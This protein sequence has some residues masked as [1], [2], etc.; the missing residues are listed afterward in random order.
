MREGPLN[1]PSAPTWL[2][3]RHAC[4]AV[5]ELRLPLAAIFVSALKLMAASLFR[6]HIGIGVVAG[7]EQLLTT[8]S[9]PVPP[10][11]EK[12]HVGLD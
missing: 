7:D 5:V 4:E 10:G 6:L 11:V 8:K 2:K 3:P 9:L 12:A 1:Y